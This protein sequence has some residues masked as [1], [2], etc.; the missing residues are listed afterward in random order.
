MQKVSRTQ[1]NWHIV[2]LFLVGLIIIA[3]DQLSKTWIRTNLLLGQPLFD[4]GFF[5]VNH[6]RNT[7]AAFGLFPNQTFVLTI[8]AFVGIIAILL[9]AFLSRRYLPFLN[10]ML[11]MSALGLVLGGTVGNLIDRV[12]FGYVT[13]FIDFKVWPTFNVA[14]SA[15]T[16]GIIIFAYFILRLAQTVK[17]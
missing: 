17:N 15:V 16:V 8:I 4:I 2:V 9:C 12:R 10:N 13:D 5:Q 14:D 1:G 3:T 6:V 11:G 7:G